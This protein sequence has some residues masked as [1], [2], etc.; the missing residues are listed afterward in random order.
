VAGRRGVALPRAI[1][2]TH[3]VAVARRPRRGRR[4][5]IFLPTGPAYRSSTARNRSRRNRT[6]SLRHRRCHRRQQRVNRSRPAA[7]AMPTNCAP[8]SSSSLLS[9]T[10]S[11]S[12]SSS[13][14]SALHNLGATLDAAVTRHAHQSDSSR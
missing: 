8:S 3:L 7:C 12:S 6:A 2:Q 10:S 5:A 9:S 13:S 1:P 4:A 14:S 11:S